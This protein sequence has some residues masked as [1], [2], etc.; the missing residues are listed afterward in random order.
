[1]RGMREL[2]PELCLVGTDV[3]KNGSLELFVKGSVETGGAMF[4]FEEDARG[5]NL[6]LK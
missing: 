3:P 6:N 1:M 4:S 2:N 5:N